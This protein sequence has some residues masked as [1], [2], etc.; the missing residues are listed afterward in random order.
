M[1]KVV[2]TV[3]A[4][5]AA[6]AA[7]CQ[8]GEVQL[9]REYQAAIREW[10]EQDVAGR[11]RAM[12]ERAERMLL[13]LPN[14]EK[15]YDEGLVAIG[16]RIEEGV[17]ADG[18]PVLNFVYD[19]AYNCR[20][21]EGYT[22]DYPLGQYRWDVSNSARAMCQ[23]TKQFVEGVLDDLFRAGKDVTIRITSSADGT[24]ISAPI[25]YGGEYGDFRYMPTVF[26]GEPLRLS[27]SRQSGIAN[28][29][30]LAYVRAQS[31]RHYLE[32]EV[33]NLAQT[34]NR[35]EYITRSYIDT[36][37][38]YR[39]SSIELVVHDAFRETIDLMTADKIQ[40]D[41]VDFNVPQAAGSY[42]EAYVLILCNDEYRL[43]FLPSVPFAMN[44]A[45][46]VRRYF[47]RALGVP[48]RHVKMLH[49]ATKQ[50]VLDEGV[51]WLTDLSQAVAGHKGDA[52]DPQM[53]VYIYY[54]G[55]GYTDYD[56]KGYLVPDG[57]EV[58]N[59]KSLAVNKKGKAPYMG[60]D[61]R[62]NYDIPLSGK[63]SG[64]LTKGL[65][66]I[67]ELLGKFKG[68]PIRRLT[69]VIDASFDGNQRN[70][71]PMLRADRKIDTKKKK[72]R[73]MNLRSD[74]VVLMAADLDRTA[75][76]F[77]A[78][79]HGFLTYFL[80]KEVKGAAGR[81]DECTYGDLYDAIERKVNKE[82][83]LQGRWQ[84]VGGA[85]GGRYKDSWRGLKIEK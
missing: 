31:V 83:A 9:N 81:M 66:G 19:I 52:L 14:D 8:N 24:D 34:R 70:G 46:M 43:P 61:G 54:V 42:E 41:Y 5:V 18:Q 23:L 38:Q 35:Y 44:D 25:A 27:V 39:R 71:Q 62:V 33:R 55:L 57:F 1:K 37:A 75:Y 20:H 82:S 10:L 12:Q 67:D 59:I 50:A 77:D 45:N 16:S 78:Q 79:H 3:L 22:D 68:F 48:E 28:N 40:D 76:A 7:W 13:A 47:T 85:A 30:Q 4:L 58:N 74:D 80:L 21:M 53:D 51:H 72:R 73:R 17:G 60:A 63:E 29:A 26:N 6:V 2:I 11:G 69:M 65:L 49:G 56:G 15:L 64:R 36:G 84:E 32:T